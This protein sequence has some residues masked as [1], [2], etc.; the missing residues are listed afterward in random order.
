MKDLDRMLL[1]PTERILFED[2]VVVIMADDSVEVMKPCKG[3]VLTLWPGLWTE[4]WASW[5]CVSTLK[6][7]VSS[8]LKVQDRIGCEDAFHSMIRVSDRISN[9]KK[10]ER[11]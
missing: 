10:R 11:E 1:P 9:T 6:M 2:E 3:W 8:K 5:P 7:A 4:S